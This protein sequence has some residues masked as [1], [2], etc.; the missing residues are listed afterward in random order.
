MSTNVS[1]FK[2]GDETIYISLHG[3]S[4]FMQYKYFNL[5]LEEWLSRGQ[6]KDLLLMAYN[7]VVHEFL[8][9]FLRSNEEKSE[10][11]TW[12]ARAE[13]AERM[14]ESLSLELLSML[15]EYG[16]NALDSWE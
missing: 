15:R 11:E 13:Y 5:S 9:G 3:Q 6:D 10:V 2:Y 12:K 1:T 14:H 8:T 7:K 16:S 4:I